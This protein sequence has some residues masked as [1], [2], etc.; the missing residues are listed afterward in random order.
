MFGSLDTVYGLVVAFA[1]GLLIGIERERNK[2]A[3]AR[4]G[5]AGVRTFMLIAVAG[6]VAERL[7]GVGL[8]VAGAFVALAALAT[9]RRTQRDDPGLT[10]EVAMLV[11]FLLG[12]L[13]MREIA[14]AAALGVAVALVLASKTRLHRFTVQTL[15]EQ[16]LH[17]ALLLIA[18]ATIVLPLLPDRSLD[19]WGVVN[20]HTLWML[21]VIVMGIQSAGYVALRALGPGTG[22]ALAGFAGGF[23]SSTAT[24]AA[25]GDRARAAPSLLLGC[26]SAALFSCVS[27]VLQLAAVIGALSPT[28]LRALALPLVAAGVAAVAVA[29]VARSR[30]VS[31]GVGAERVAPGRPFEP[32]HALTYVA[33]VAAILL[34]A[35]IVHERL[36]EAGLAVAAGVSGFADVHAAAASVAQLVAA[37]RVSVDDAALPVLIALI[38]NSLA[39]F[40]MAWLRG[41]SGYALRV[42]PGLAAIAIAFAAEL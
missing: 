38:A 40:G 32:R 11:A 42:L 6:A 1:I 31:D 18:A 9:Y 27:T 33:I 39:K 4:R 7:G 26:V 24:I 10:T 41:G 2:G 23:V 12:A 8:A 19:P 5:A 20:P 17:D 3:G 34:L 22:L 21:V 29:A 25:F 14:L 28:M 13:A 16:E 37:S 15:T 36:G 30:A 35:A